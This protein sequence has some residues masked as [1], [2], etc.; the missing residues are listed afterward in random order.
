MVRW[1]KG[2]RMRTGRLVSTLG[3]LMVV[4]CFSSALA[5]NKP[6]H[7]VSGAIAYADLQQTHPQTL[8]QVVALL[9]THPH[10][11]TKWKPKLTQS[12]V[13]PEERDLLLFMLAARWPDD[14]RGDTSFHHGTWH[15]INFPY[16][17]GATRE[18]PDRRAA[19][20]KR[21]ERVSG[22]SGYC[23]RRGA[24]GSRR[25]ALLDLSSHR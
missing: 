10:F 1:E 17:C 25:G 8:A 2:D 16:T 12:F 13:G 18:C 15:Y 23:T 6:G 22:Q 21:V 20:R 14:I 3:L 4:S 11:E 24:R 9:K 19:A 5:W 7:M